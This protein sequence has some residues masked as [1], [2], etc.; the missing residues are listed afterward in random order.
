MTVHEAYA[1]ALLA[2]NAWQ[3]ELERVYGRKAGDA[4]YGAR[5]TATERLAGL[6]AEFARATCAWRNHPETACTKRCDCA[7]D[8]GFRSRVGVSA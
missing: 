3:A 8:H 6:H 2:D 4:R 1:Q 5:G 7:V